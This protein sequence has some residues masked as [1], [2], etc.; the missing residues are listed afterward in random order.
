VVS[1]WS[2]NA[3]AVLLLGRFLSWVDNFV[4]DIYF[5]LND[6]VARRAQGRIVLK[7][8]VA[9]LD[10]TSPFLP[11]PSYICRSSYYFCVV[12]FRLRHM[13]SAATAYI[14]WICFQI[15][16]YMLAGDGYRTAVKVCVQAFCSCSSLPE[17]IWLLFSS[18]DQMK[19]FSF[20][21]P[22]MKSRTWNLYPAPSNVVRIR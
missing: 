3:D 15:V 2:C 18:L 17:L 1:A 19:I 4:F 5:N 14:Q 8:I 12:T 22:L 21:S 16:Y 10:L 7:K 20:S 6:V 9:V 13:I 11:S